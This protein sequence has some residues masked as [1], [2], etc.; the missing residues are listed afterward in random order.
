MN[1]RRLRAPRDDQA[2]LAVPPLD[3][4]TKLIE[5]N[6]RALRDQTHNFQGRAFD[7][8]RAR[9]RAEVMT[10]AREQLTSLGASLP[11]RHWDPES[12]APL[13]VSGHQP[14]LFHAG[15]WIKNFAVGAI[16]DRA[17]GV[18]IHLV[19]DNDL[20]KS[21]GIRVPRV[22]GTTL[23]SRTIE[24]EDTQPEVPFEAWRSHNSRLFHSFRQRVV[25]QLGGL[26]S[27][28][29]IDEFWPIAKQ[30][31]DEDP[32]LGRAFAGARRLYEQ[33]WGLRSWDLPMSKVCDGDAFRWF[34]SHILAHLPRFH[35]IHNAALASYRATNRIRSHNHPVANLGRVDDWLEAPVWVWHVD[36]PRRLPLLVRARGRVTEIRAGRN[37]DKPVELRLSP[38]TDA[39]CAVERLAEWHAAG[40]RIRTRAL[41]TTMFARLFLS[42]LFIHGIGG[43][44]Y[45]EL[46]D[47][48][49]RAFFGFEP[50][51]FLTLSMTVWLGMNDY[52]STEA[53][54]A[55][56]RRLVRDLAHNPD[57]HLAAPIKHEVESLLLEKRDAIAAPTLTRR[58]RIARWRRLHDVNARLRPHVAELQTQALERVRSLEAIESWNRAAHA[59]D[60]SFVLHDPAHLRAAYAQ[61]TA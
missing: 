12:P 43:A 33:R 34:L 9:A 36:R 20:P 4:A 29:I 18:P 13:V 22:A 11:S 19:V 44:K 5:T 15:V 31:M 50:P 57:R 61:A 45:D 37:G 26:V 24:F 51:A 2:V 60:Y 32:R 48:I 7:V 58:E 53:A 39:C 55:Q 49:M 25:D 46:G 28:P 30:I 14:E 16:A 27:A 47:E 21:A 6:Q 59:R 42:D 35:Q 23:R 52:P 56:A 1:S 40:W 54:L 38:D 8:L 41:T 10:A 3:Q 17:A